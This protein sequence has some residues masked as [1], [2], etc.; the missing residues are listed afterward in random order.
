MRSKD[1]QAGL[2]LY[3]NLHYNTPYTKTPLNVHEL[4]VVIWYYIVL[5]K[6]ENIFFFYG[7]DDIYHQCYWHGDPAPSG[8]LTSKAKHYN[9]F[10][11]SNVDSTI[12]QCGIDDPGSSKLLGISSTT[13]TCKRAIRQQWVGRLSND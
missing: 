13:Q 1:K 11:F 9:R 5:N 3:C 10:L 12:V 7:I 6:L 4:S 8:P 2:K